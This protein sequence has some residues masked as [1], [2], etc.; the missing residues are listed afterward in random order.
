MKDVT[1][2]MGKSKVSLEEKKSTLWVTLL[3][4]CVILGGIAISFY[5]ADTLDERERSAWKA[6]AN[7]DSRRLTEFGSLALN[8]A[9]V[10]LSIIAARLNSNSDGQEQGRENP[11]RIDVAQADTIAF[12]FIVFAEFASQDPNAIFP[13]FKSVSAYSLQSE[14]SQKKY[15]QFIASETFRRLAQDTYE[16]QSPNNIPQVIVGETASYEGGQKLASLGVRVRL[17]GSEGVLIGVFDLVG[18]F[19]S[20]MAT[21]APDGLVLRLNESSASGRQQSVIGGPSPLPNTIQSFVFPISYGGVEWRYSWDMLPNYEGGRDNSIGT[22]VRYGGLGLFTMFG[23]L[24][25]VLLQ[26]NRRISIAVRRRTEELA[27]AR[28]QAEIANRTKSEFLANMSHE[29]RTPLNSVIGFS[30][31]LESQVLG[32][33]SWERYRDYATDIRQ[34]GRHLLSLINDILDLSKAEAG[35]LTLDEAYI[36]P[37]ELIEAAVRLVHERARNAGQ[38]L[39]ISVADPT[40]LLRCDERRVKQILLNLLSNAIKFTPRGGSITVRAQPCDDGGMELQVIDTGIGMKK[41][42]IPLALAK[43]QQLDSKPRG[44]F[45]GTGLGLPLVENLARLHD[46]D[47]RIESQPGKGTSVAIKFGKERVGHADE[48]LGH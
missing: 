26:V 10:T 8:Q 47:L 2:R 18:F 14:D 15:T 29:L 21:V 4:L 1:K 5:A 43:F 23:L 40:I 22:L 44:D 16:A 19:K 20:F 37:E 17:Q 6:R 28:D 13:M 33:D 36:S 24:L 45:A 7:D 41:E 38:E 31:I 32:P 9:K 34:S 11:E 48:V 3:T 27:R 42:D 25:A 39:T 30:E 35:H 46:A 12:E